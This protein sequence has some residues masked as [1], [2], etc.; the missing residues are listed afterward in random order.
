MDF[1]KN[2]QPLEL[3]LEQKN[4]W[5]NLKKAW[6]KCKKVGIDFLSCCGDLF[7]VNGNAV[8]EYEWEVDATEEGASYIR[9]SD[10]CENSD[11]C[12]E[13]DIYSFSGDG[14]DEDVAILK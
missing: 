1:N 10:A 3:N 14:F 9:L 11:Y 13:I 8:K 12:L 5:E 7:P 4:A 2:G 6:N